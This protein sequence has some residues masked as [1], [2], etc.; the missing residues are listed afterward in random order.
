[1]FLR[2]LFLLTLLPLVELVL[3]VWLSA[4]TDW[5]LTVLFVLGTG[6]LGAWLIRWQGWRA[7]RNIR[8]ELARGELPAESIQDGLFI[9]VAGLLLITPGVLTDV[10]GVVLLVPPFRRALGKWLRRR[11]R[12]TFAVRSFS[13]GG[14]WEPGGREPDGTVIDV[15]STPATRP[16]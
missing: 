13:T 10:A 12:T 9:L 11:W 4:H 6:A 1:M 3:L 5:R 14:G 15:A 16:D 7:W 2:I 8:D